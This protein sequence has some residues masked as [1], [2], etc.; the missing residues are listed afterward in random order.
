MVAEGYNASK[1]IHTMN[2][3]VKA[4]IPIASAIY[5]ILWEHLPAFEGFKKI[6]TFL[7]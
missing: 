2:E 3:S 5:E 4:S 7:V 6:E 1:C